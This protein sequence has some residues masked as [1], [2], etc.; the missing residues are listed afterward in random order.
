[1]RM[2]VCGTI[3]DCHSRTESWDIRELLCCVQ[4]LRML[5]GQK[6]ESWEIHIEPRMNRPMT[7]AAADGAVQQQTTH[8]LEL[9]RLDTPTRGAREKLRQRN[10]HTPTLNTQQ[11]V[12]T[13][14]H[15]HNE[16]TAGGTHTHTHTHTPT[17]N[18]HTHTHTHTHTEHTAAGTDTEIDTHT[19]HTAA[20]THTHTHSRYSSL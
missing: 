3:S 2:S 12:D 17:L 13:E 9:R 14:T 4:T 15:T 16:H 18:T 1:V 7:A 5:A 20:G 10:T 6:V 11:Q 19:E 8:G